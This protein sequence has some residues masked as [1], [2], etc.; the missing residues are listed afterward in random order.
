MS[1]VALS[2][3]SLEFAGPCVSL[4]FEDSDADNLD[5]C[6]TVLGKICIVLLEPRSRS[7]EVDMFD[8]PA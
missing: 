4:L 6:V 2:C 5:V 1:L 8:Y 3:P 7:E